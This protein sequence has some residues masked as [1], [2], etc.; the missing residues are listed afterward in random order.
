MTFITCWLYKTMLGKCHHFTLTDS[1]VII[2][3]INLAGS[4]FK[5]KKMNGRGR[6]LDQKIWFLIIN[7]V[8]P[9]L[10]L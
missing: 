6:H 3:K 1:F 8:Q 4:E 7:Q 9:T 10:F 5:K 2:Q